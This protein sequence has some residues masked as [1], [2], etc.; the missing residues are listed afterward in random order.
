[1]WGQTELLI[2]FWFMNLCGTSIRIYDLKFFVSK[3]EL[4]GK[5]LDLKEEGFCC[6]EKMTWRTNS[7]LDAVRDC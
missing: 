1:M 3:A 6:T 4:C 2:R 7:C 5:W